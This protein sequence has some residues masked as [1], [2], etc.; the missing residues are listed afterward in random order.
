MKKQK[1]TLEENKKNNKQEK[2]KNNK[3]EKEKDKQ[4]NEDKKS[5]NNKQENEDKKSKNEVFLIYDK[6]NYLEAK[7]LCK[8]YSGRLANE[9]DLIKAYK[10]GANWCLWGWIDGEKI[11]YPVQEKFWSDIEQ[12]HKGYCGPTAGINKIENIDPFKR[13]SVTCYGIKPKKTEND[14]DLI[15]DIN[16][17]NKIDPLV[18]A[19]QTCKKDK[20]IEE[21][22]KWLEKQKKSVSLLSFNKM[23]WSFLE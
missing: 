7:E 20:Q 18:Q 14:N 5:K 15:E 16:E 4:E 6:F 1:K 3:K 22:K 11:A 9:S 2:D 23:K 13:F 17:I 10:N 19:I 21:Q 8:S 12:T